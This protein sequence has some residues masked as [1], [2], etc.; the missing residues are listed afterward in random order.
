MITKN[1]MQL[2]SLSEL[3]TTLEV[4]CSSHDDYTTAFEFPKKK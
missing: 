2:K 4:V 1:A 3:H